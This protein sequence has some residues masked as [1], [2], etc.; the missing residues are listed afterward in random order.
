LHKRRLAATAAAATSAA[1][2]PAASAI[3][4]AAIAGERD[5]ARQQSFRHMI[6]LCVEGDDAQAVSRLQALRWRQ[7]RLCAAVAQTS[8]KRASGCTRVTVT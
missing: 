4:A 3:A 2:V 8:A 1:T 5:T 7:R 6:L